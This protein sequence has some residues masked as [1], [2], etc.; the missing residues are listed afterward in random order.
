MDLFEE[1]MGYTDIHLDIEELKKRADVL[2]I[3][4]LIDD[5]RSLVSIIV[6]PENSKLNH[7]IYKHDSDVDLMIDE[8]EFIKRVYVTYY[9]G[10]AYFVDDEEEE[11]EEDF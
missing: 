7:L 4:S 8:V 1:E 3:D 9:A 10:F 6:G 11:D 5:I 2:D